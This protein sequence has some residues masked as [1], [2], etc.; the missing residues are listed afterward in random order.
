MCVTSEYLDGSVSP[1]W[2]L[3]QCP[4]APASYDEVRGWPNGTTWEDY[5]QDYYDSR[6]G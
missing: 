4:A 3:T 6:L 1:Q 2:V 5:Y